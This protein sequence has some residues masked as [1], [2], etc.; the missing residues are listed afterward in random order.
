MNSKIRIIGGTL[1]S[2]LISVPDEIVRPTP[3]RIR[4]TLFNWLREDI[5]GA[6]CLDL[7][8][9]SGALGFEA[10]SRGAKHVTFIEKDTHIIRNL[11][12]NSET[13]NITNAAFAKTDA[14]TFLKKTE[15]KSFDIVFLDPPYAENLIKPCVDLLVSQQLLSPHAK[16][17]IEHNQPLTGM[18]L[19]ESV[20]LIHNKKAGHVYYGVLEFSLPKR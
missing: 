9:G 20:T 3:N 8:A 6:Q 10:I 5:V 14:L 7:F 15:A 11:K 4:E 18:L 12:K 2:R 13:L 16:I 17:Y 19:P 1:R